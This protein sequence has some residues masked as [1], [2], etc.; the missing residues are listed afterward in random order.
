MGD[1]LASCMQ[2]TSFYVGYF[3]EVCRRIGL[4]VN[5]GKSKVICLNREEELE[6]EVRVD[7]MQLERSRNLNTWDCF[8]DETST[9]TAECHRKVVIGRRVAA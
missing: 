7:G 6:C 9:D 2:M 3:F 1:C 8:L 4:K 5:A